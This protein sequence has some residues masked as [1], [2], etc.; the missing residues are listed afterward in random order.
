LTAATTVEAAVSAIWTCILVLSDR[1]E[2][3]TLGIAEEVRRHAPRHS[4]QL[5]N[6]GRWRVSV[7]ALSKIPKVVVVLSALLAGGN[8]GAE[9][10]LKRTFC[11]RGRDIKAPCRY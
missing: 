10:L 6:N 8:S 2:K 3:S 5:P 7:P 9:R 4:L 1:L 11:R